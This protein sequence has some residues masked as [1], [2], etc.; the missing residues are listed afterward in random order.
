MW[1]ERANKWP[2]S[3]TVSCMMIMMMI[4]LC[5]ILQHFFTLI[6]PN[7]DPYIGN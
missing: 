5:T 4:I 6:Y 1:P 2:N 3:M 7:T